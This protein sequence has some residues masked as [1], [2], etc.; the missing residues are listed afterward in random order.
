LRAPKVVLVW[1][2]LRFAGTL[3]EVDEK[4]WRFDPDGT[5]VRGTIR[6][7]LRNG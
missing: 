6:I 3:V 7:V 2:T 1:G 4:W 5:P